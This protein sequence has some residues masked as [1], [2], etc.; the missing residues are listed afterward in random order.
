MP[1]VVRLVT[2]TYV[3]FYRCE[4]EWHGLLNYIMIIYLLY[5]ILFMLIN[6]W[7]LDSTIVYE[8]NSINFILW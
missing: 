1:L 3:P 4:L 8:S 5:I 6:L 2:T 7:L